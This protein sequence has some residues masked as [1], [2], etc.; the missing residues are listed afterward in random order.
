[1]PTQ[2]V[3][4]RAKSVLFETKIRLERGEGRTGDVVGDLVQTGRAHIPKVGSHHQWD[5]VEPGVERALPTGGLVVGVILDA[6]GSDLAELVDDVTATATTAT[7]RGGA[8]GGTRGER[9]GWRE[10]QTGTKGAT[11]G[12]SG[13]RRGKTSTETSTEGRSSSTKSRP[14]GKRRGGEGSGRDRSRNVISLG[15]MVSPSWKGEGRWQRDKSGIV[16]SWRLMISLR[17]GE[18]CRG[19]GRGAETEDVKPGS[20]SPREPEA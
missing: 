20:T 10:G 3:S 14:E 11:E 1:M 6:R 9:R 16:V 19:G 12:R 4:K 2:E 8:G 17:W 13:S 15:L 7:A 5:T 18:G